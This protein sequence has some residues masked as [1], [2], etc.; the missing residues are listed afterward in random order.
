MSQKK[1]PE[2]QSRAEEIA[3]SPIFA[4]RDAANSTDSEIPSN[5]AQFILETVIDLLQARV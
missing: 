5:K 1:Y 4:I 3:N 2:L